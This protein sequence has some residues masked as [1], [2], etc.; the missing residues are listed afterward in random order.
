MTPETAAREARDG[1][2]AK[3]RRGRGKARPAPGEDGAEQPVARVLQLVAAL[4][5]EHEAGGLPAVVEA[6]DPNERVRVMSWLKRILLA[7]EDERKGWEDQIRRLETQIAAA[8]QAV[9]ETRAGAAD[10]ASQHHRLVADLK[11]LHEHQRSIWQLERRRL[12]ITIEGYER[13]RQR[14]ALRRAARLARPAVAAGLILAALSAVALSGDSSAAASGAP[15]YLDGGVRAAL[16][17]LG[18]D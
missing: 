16:V 13:K 11:L 3:I 8:Q 18:A 2:A 5:A 7:R 6:E 17:S 14:S 12:E 1:G 10:A 15:R 4:K 9:E